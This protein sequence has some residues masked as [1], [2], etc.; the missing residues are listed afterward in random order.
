[1]AIYFAHAYSSNERAPNENAN[2]LLR[3][4]FPKKE[5]VR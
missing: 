5:N 2:G 1:M 4:Y 3:Q